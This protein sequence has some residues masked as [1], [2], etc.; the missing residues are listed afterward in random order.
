MS[1][2]TR[3]RFLGLTAAAG[4][5]RSQQ[6]TKPNIVFILMDDLGWADLGCYGSTF[7]ETPNLDRLA[8]EGMR[9][10]NAYSACPV[11]SPTRASIMTGKY[12]ARLRL[13]NFIPGRSPRP[14]AKLIPPEFEQQLPIAESTIAELL[15][16]QGY[17]TAAIGKW[18]LGGPQYSPNKQGFD[19]AFV[20]A[21]RHLAQG[22]KVDGP[23][24]PRPDEDRAERLTEEAGAFVAKNHSRPFF[25]YLTHH[26]PH[27][28]LEARREL[29]AKYQDKLNSPKFRSSRESKGPAQNHPVYAAMIE[30]ADQLIGRLMKKLEETGVA[31]RTVVIFTSDN[32]GL[33]AP[34][35][36]DRPTTSNAP[37]RD[38]KGYLYE[39][40][41]RVPLIVRWP[42]TVKPGSR[43]DVPVSSVD[44]Y[45]TLASMTSTRDVA[46]NS[47]DGADITPLLRD[48][49]ASG[50][51]PLFWH[52]PHYSNQGGAPG[53]AVRLGDYKLIQFYEDHHLELYNVRED[54][55]ERYE[56]SGKLP[57]KRDELNKLL[58]NWLGGTKAVMPVENPKYD[59]ARQLQGLRWVKATD[60]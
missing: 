15:R 41:I 22:W 5:A 42:G 20:T 26:L 51:H 32:G 6:E 17:A 4:M 3:R 7:Y 12:P 44:W 38:G 34:E 18:H 27:I 14:H 9:F 39:G 31:G 35:F 37:L 11:C 28:P 47:R 45:P 24:Q 36:E 8:R 40:G 21:G 58:Q 16:E 54:P 48:P 43:C 33:T 60:E 57:A 50:A 52:Y 23:F 55:G 56:L 30:N 2:L 46:V 49:R 25:L 59:A 53:G 13:T 19:F 10:T 29:V 1:A